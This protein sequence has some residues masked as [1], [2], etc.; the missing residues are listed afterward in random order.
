M[1][2]T[3]VSIINT[4]SI[5][6]NSVVALSQDKHTEKTR[7]KKIQTP[8][9]NCQSIK[10]NFRLLFGVFSVMFIVVQFKLTKFCIQPHNWIF[11][12]IFNTSNSAYNIISMLLAFSFGLII[13]NARW[14]QNSKLNA[15]RVCSQNFENSKILSFSIDASHTT[16]KHTA[17]AHN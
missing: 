7:T 4:F 17:G 13:Q 11:W 6:E 2:H 15:L 10:A 14:T 3:K 9:V 16:S 8:I 12:F 1:R 5:L